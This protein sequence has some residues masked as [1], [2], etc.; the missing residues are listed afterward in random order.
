MASDQVVVV[1]SDEE[2]H[3]IN[4]SNS[5]SRSRVLGKRRLRADAVVVS[6]SDDDVQFVGSRPPHR[7]S[8]F[9][10]RHFRD[11]I[12]LF[13]SPVHGHTENSGL[14]DPEIRAIPQIP[15]LQS[16]VDRQESCCI[17]LDAFSKGEVVM[18]LSCNHRFHNQCLRPWLQSKP[19]C[20]LCKAKVSKPR[21]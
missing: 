18:F 20:P 4:A 7:P 8:P 11:G 13:F 6:E 1:D 5:K 15:I 3:R 10:I 9:H 17:C 19:I 2:S 21:R 14:S 16:D 12:R